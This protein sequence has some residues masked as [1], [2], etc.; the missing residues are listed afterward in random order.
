[1]FNSRISCEENVKS[2]GEEH[3]EQEDH[4]RDRDYA[5]DRRHDIV[6]ACLHSVFAPEDC[7]LDNR[8]AAGST[9]AD[10]NYQGHRAHIGMALH[11]AAD[12]QQQDADHRQH[13]EPQQRDEVRFF[14]SKDAL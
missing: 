7:H 2:R 8:A 6:D 3:L 12:I 5:Q 11:K 13:D 14:I 4:H 10:H 1:M 9:G